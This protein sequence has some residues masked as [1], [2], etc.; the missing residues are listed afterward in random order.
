MDSVETV[1]KRP[2]IGA[3]EES[4]MRIVLTGASGQLG[5]YLVDRL[6]E[7]GHDLVAWSGAT[8][9]R[10]GHVALTPI[11]LTRSA[12]VERTLD[13]ISPD[14]ILHAAAISSAEAVR[15]DLTRAQA[16]NVEATMTLAEWCIRRARR[17]VF[18]STDLVFDGSRPWNREDDPAEPILAYGRTKRDAEDVA[19]G[20][21]GGLIARV[22]LLYGPS[23]CGRPN[24]L[25]RSMSALRRGDPQRFFEDEFRTPLHYATAADVLVRLVE[26]G[27]SGIVHVGG[28]ERMSRWELMRRLAREH[29]LDERLVLANRRADAMLAEPRPA[30]V[31]LDTTKLAAWL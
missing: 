14:V 17:L 1:V 5:A 6:A 12:H 10:R 30:D 2:R 26:S 23:R 9:G 16:V 24:Y 29:G 11:D 13:A 20:V 19:R 22:A 25:D 18:T 31:S 27:A 8:E 21:P 7:S 15:L 4:V 3:R 28:A